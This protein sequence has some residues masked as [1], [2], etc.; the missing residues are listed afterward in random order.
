MSVCML[1]SDKEQEDSH[2]E[3]SEKD[4]YGDN[5]QHNKELREHYKT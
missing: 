3:E 1:V 4:L 2:H 5:S